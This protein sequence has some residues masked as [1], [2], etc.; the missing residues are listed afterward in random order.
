MAYAT[1]RSIDVGEIPVIDMA[2]LGSSDDAR[3]MEVA[4]R[5]RE[6]PSA[7]GSSTSEHASAGA[8]DAIFDTSRRFF[9]LLPETSGVTINASTWLAG[10]ARRRL[11]QGRRST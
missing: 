3:R 5:M 7:S 4:S 11:R 8:V 1:A 10:V 2:G 6:P 9:A